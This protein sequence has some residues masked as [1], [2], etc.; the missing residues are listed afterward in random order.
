MQ[1]QDAL[2]DKPSG[3]IYQSTDRDLITE[4]CGATIQHGALN[5]RIYL[6]SMND[7]ESLPL[8]EALSQLAK[9]KRYTKIFAKVKKRRAAPFLDAGYAPEAVVPGYF[10][11]IEDAVFLCKYYD[12]RRRRDPAP[13][14]IRTIV[15]DAL[16]DE[17]TPHRVPVLP[18]DIRLRACTPE[19]TEAMASLYRKVFKSYPF[20]IH[21]P[22]YLLET[23]RTH[24]RYFCMERRGYLFAASSAETDL[25]NGV[26]ELTDFAVDPSFRGMGSASLLLTEMEQALLSSTEKMNVLYT[27]ARARTKAVNRLFARAGYTFSG[28]LTNNTHIGGQIESM[29]VWYKKLH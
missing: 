2:L 16:R 23:M 27:I 26:A 29:T 10:G 5:R 22:A 28:I 20:P 19:D 1:S 13:A 6:M 14:E 15:E 24:V 7:A 17:D 8:I 18:N 25:K 21:D 4:V 9:R 3:E 11:G 12:E